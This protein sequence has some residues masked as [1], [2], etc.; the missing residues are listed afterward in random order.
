MDHHARRPRPDITYLSRRIRPSSA[1]AGPE[2]GRI[3]AAP[4]AASTDVSP[5]PA[6]SSGLSLERPTASS[7]GLSLERPRAGAGGPGTADRG[8]RPTLLAPVR[9]SARLF[10][11]P[12]FRDTRQLSEDVP[13]VRLNARQSGIGTLLVHGARS[14]AWEDIDQVTGAENARGETA[15]V[16]SPTAGNRKLVAFHDGS[17]AVTLRH[18]QRFRRAI[19]IAQDA[20]LV[21]SLFGESALAVSPKTP[22]GKS[23]VLYISRIGSLLELRADYVEAADDQA[24]WA[25]FGFTM[26][27]PTHVH[28]GRR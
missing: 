20:P 25:A 15:G 10:S 24:I 12:G 27:T 2:P 11:A 22:D 17:A 4:P 28:T 6:P 13:I 16:A 8:S 14:T 18:V 23:A 19:F 5:S 1:P 21:V 7:V 26:T 3:P 9:D